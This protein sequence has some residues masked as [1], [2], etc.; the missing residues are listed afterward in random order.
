MA[1]GQFGLKV[2]R[3]AGMALTWRT[4]EFIPTQSLYF[5]SPVKSARAG[6]TA[7]GGAVTSAW[8]EAHM[9]KLQD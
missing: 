1:K 5:A 6:G 4:V 2:K 7:L 3:P 8:K 9:A